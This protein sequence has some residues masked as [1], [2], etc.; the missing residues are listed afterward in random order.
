MAVVSETRKKNK[1]F[2]GEKDFVTVADHPR[3]SMPPSNDWISIAL[4]IKLT[5]SF[6]VN[7]PHPR[8]PGEH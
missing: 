8:S 5:T 4:A 2:G 6:G 1:S 3:R 7:K